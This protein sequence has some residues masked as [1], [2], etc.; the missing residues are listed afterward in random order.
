MSIQALRQEADFKRALSEVI[1]DCVKDPRLSGMCSITKVEITKDQKYAK[2]YV[3]VF[4]QEEEGRKASVEVLNSASGFI[5]RELNSRV[6]MRRIPALHFVL[7]TSIEYS[8][9]ISQ[10]LREIMPQEDAQE[11]SDDGDVQ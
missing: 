6:R 3:S 10:M 7:D 5:A 1:R 9:H 11:G 2:I 4:G 8:V